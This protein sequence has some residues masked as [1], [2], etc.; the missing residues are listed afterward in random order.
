MGRNNKN[1]NFQAVFPRAWMGSEEERE[2]KRA[3]KGCILL[4]APFSF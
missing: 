1:A 4:A 2:S 3:A